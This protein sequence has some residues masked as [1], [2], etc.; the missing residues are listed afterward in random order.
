MGCNQSYPLPAGK[1]KHGDIPRQIDIKQED[2]FQFESWNKSPKKQLSPLRNVLNGEEIARPQSE[3][4][5]VIR[6]RLTTEMMSSISTNL[7][8]VINEDIPQCF[9]ADCIAS[10]EDGLNSYDEASIKDDQEQV[11]EN[12]S[13]VTN[14]S[15]SDLIEILTIQ[16]MIREDE[17]LFEENASSED[18]T[19]PSSNSNNASNLLVSTDLG[20]NED[21]DNAHVSSKKSIKD[22]GLLLM[23]GVC[24]FFYFAASITFAAW[25]GMKTFQSVRYFVAPPPRLSVYE[26]HGFNASQDFLGPGVM[27]GSNDFQTEATSASM[28]LEVT[29]YDVD[30]LR[31]PCDENTNQLARVATG[32]SKGTAL[33]GLVIDIGC[34]KLVAVLLNC[35]K[36]QMQLTAEKRLIQRVAL[37][38]MQRVKQTLPISLEE[39]REMVDEDYYFI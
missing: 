22:R 39:A 32:A 20:M 11:A 12:R 25:F 10:E 23:T 19:S 17:T 33:G 18:S 3:E 14:L 8:E 2:A 36:Q 1:L 13:H 26:L 16:S 5:K 15:E 30:R 6:E 21:T 35:L 37:L 34:K 38:I 7:L 27:F 24:L 31:L 4:R 28:E 29:G 9:D